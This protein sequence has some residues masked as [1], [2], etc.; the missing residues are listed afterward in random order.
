MTAE[1]RAEVERLLRRRDLPPRVRERLEMVKAAALRQDLAAIAAWSGRTVRPVKR[2]LRR[3]GEG[4]AAAVA[5]ASR[6]GRPPRADSAYRPALERAVDTP[7]RDL[8]LP[9]D[10]WTSARLSTYLVQITGGRIAPGW[11]RVLLAQQHFAC[12][13]PK[14]TLEHLQDPA[15]VAA[16]EADLAAAEKKVAAEPHRYEMHYQDETPM[17]TNP[18]LCK[19]WQRR[20]VQPRLP[21]AGTNR[22]VTVFGSALA[23][24]MGPPRM[25]TR[26]RSSRVSRPS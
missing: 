3:Y 22:R 1:Q 10:V 4:G 14:H 16:C 20:G 25:G 9:F 2:W 24:P 8:G 26:R 17:E 18:Y 15:A 11:L 7:P 6:A 13:Q 23:R 21:A 12:G 19:V 5:D